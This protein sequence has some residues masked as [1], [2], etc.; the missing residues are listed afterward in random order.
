MKNK[1]KKEDL[2]HA[3]YLD[4][5]RVRTMRLGRIAGGLVLFVLPYYIY[6][7]IFQTHIPVEFSLFWRGLTISLAIIFIFLTLSRFRRNIRII[8]TVYFLFLSAIMSMG[9]AYA[10]HTNLHSIFLIGLMFTV[11]G[12][13]ACSTEGY[14]YLSFIFG[15]SVAA[16]FIYIILY[17]NNL[18]QNVV[19]LSNPILMMLAA[20][21]LA[22]VRDKL[23]FKAF[24]ATRNALREKTRIEAVNKDLK[25]MQKQI[26]TQEKLASLGALTAGVAHEIKNPLNFINNFADISGELITDLKKCIEIEKGK[27]DKNVLLEINENIKNLATFTTKINKHGQIAND[28][29]NNMLR[30]SRGKAGEYHL[31]D[32]NKII[33]E[34]LELAYHG[35]RAKDSKFIV[36]IRQ[37]LKATGKINIDSQGISR[38]ILNIINNAFYSVQQKQ[39]AEIVD[40]VPEV[41]VSTKTLTKTVEIKIKDNGGGIPDSSR[42]KLFT[43]FYTTKPAGVGTGLGLSITHDIIVQEH[44]GKISVE[45]KEGEY[46]EFIISLPKK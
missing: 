2:W 5:V 43:P 31:T 42:D 34:Y 46:T 13:F 32:I 19:Y 16:L 25:E 21:F 30:H 20:L 6:E 37:K 9:T 26:I 10:L 38:A 33:E 29:V 7:D 39:H 18:P 24:K 8:R 28:I 17:F 44:K 40:Y 3:I 45:S 23:F 36:K 22:N 11:F 15:P 41:L 35:I 1:T 4:E 12:V 27:I 14:K